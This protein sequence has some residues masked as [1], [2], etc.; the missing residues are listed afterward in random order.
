MPG[1]DTLIEEAQELMTACLEDIPTTHPIHK[2]IDVLL[3]MTRQL[4]DSN[5]ALEAQTARTMNLV[6]TVTDTMKDTSAA[7]AA[8][9]DRLRRAGLPS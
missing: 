6:R 1:Y 7:L 9:S 3:R 8:T 4:H 2:A 5:V